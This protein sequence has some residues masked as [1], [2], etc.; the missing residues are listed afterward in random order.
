[1]SKVHQETT[2]GLAAQEE[3]RAKVDLAA[4]AEDRRNLN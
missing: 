2:L 3:D 1:L 4:R